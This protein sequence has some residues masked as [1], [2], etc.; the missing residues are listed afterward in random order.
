LTPNDPNPFFLFEE[1]KRKAGAVS[2][3]RLISVGAALVVAIFLTRLLD[4]DLYGAYRKLW[5]I[6]AMFGTIL[7]GTVISTLYYRAGTSDHKGQAA[8]VA[9]LLSFIGGLIVAFASYAGAPFWAGLL[10]APGL[11]NSFRMFAPYLF[12]GV[13][14]AS[15]EPLFVIYQRKKWL[16]G[17]TLAYNLIESAL[18]VIP[19]AAGLPIEHVV[20]IMSAG[21]ALRSIA[22]VLFAMK[23]HVKLPGPGVLRRELRPSIGYAAGIIMVSIAGIAAVEADKWIVGI[24][25]ESDALYAIYVVGAKKLPF[26]GA[27]TS[28][29]AAGVVAQYSSLL[30]QKHY[31]EALYACRRAST[32]VISILLPMIAV[33]WVLSEHILV[34][35]FE[36]YADSAPIFRIYLYVLL[37][38]SVF[39]SSFVLAHG[40][41]RINALTGLMELIVNIALSITLI[42]Y[43]GLE[44]PAW[45]TLAAHISYTIILLLY[46]KYRLGL[47]PGVF[48][49]KKELW[50]VIPVTILVFGAS[51]YIRDAIGGVIMPVLAGGV[52]AILAIVFLLW[53]VR[54]PEA[55]KESV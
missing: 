43:I 18:I 39:V 6:Y 17:Y 24:F 35:L 45:A 38:N 23:H 51:L 20:L 37:S 10:N 36:K 9:L 54:D 15:A 52:V 31:T 5:L 44:G 30:K 32:I 53:V 40:L 46:C 42:H 33:S 22:V 1:L 50:P 16:V 4:E 48:F 21:P 29:I 13:F 19:F 7:T 12:F 34:L 55:Q 41:S 2:A 27:I 47:S 8:G 49:P 28:A 25:F 11:E 14:A 3:T 26:I